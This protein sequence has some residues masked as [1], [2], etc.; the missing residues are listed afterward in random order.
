MIL[1]VA[2][3]TLLAIA[4]I[5]DLRTGRPRLRIDPSVDALL[6]TDDPERL[7][8][9]RI[10]RSFDGGASLILALRSEG[11]VYETRML[12]AVAGLTERIAQLDGVRA[13]RSLANA[14]RLRPVDGDLELAPL[15]ERPPRDPA[16]LAALRK[17]VESNPL[18]A[19]SLVSED[20]TVTTLVVELRE[21][22][23]RAFTESELDLRIRA[24]AEE[25]V[26]EGRAWL[27]GGPHFKAETSR[28]LLADLARIVPLAF[29]LV[30]AIALLA[31]RTLRGVLIPASSVLIA[32]VWTLGFTAATAGSL[33][34]V[35][36]VVP[37]LVLV[38]GFAYAVHVLAAHRD[39]AARAGPDAAPAAVTR[40][41]LGHVALP[42]LLAGLTT[43]AGL[44]ALA[45][46]PLRA[47]RQF[48]L[49]ATAGVLATM[50]VGLTW[51]PAWLA[52]LRPAAPQPKRPHGP[53]RVDRLLGR[54]A[55][56]DV[57]HRRVILAAG[58]LVALVGLYGTTRIEVRTNLVSSFP[59]DSDVRRD[60][61]A[62][63]AHLKGAGQLQVVVEAPAR[64]AFKEPE[65][66]RAIADLQRRL[67]E[68][69]Q[70]GSV[71]SLVDHVRLLNRG[72]HDGAPEHDRVPD[73]RRLVSQLLFFGAHEE[74]ARH[75]DTAYRTTV[76]ELRTTA[77][78]SD[79]LA[80]LVR[81]IER[82]G[83]GLPAGLEARVTG[84]N[85]LVVRALDDIARGQALS[86]AIAFG[87]IFAILALLFT[88]L[89]SGLMALLPNALPVIVYFGALGLAGVGLGATTGLV[90]CLVL[91]VAVDD[92]IH[93][94]ARFNAEARERADEAAGVRAALRSVGRPVTFTSV[95]LCLGFLVLTTAD[96]RNQV[97][98][99]AL[100]S[101]TLAVAWLVDVTFTPALAS[102][103]R[104]VTL[105]DVLALD[106]GRSPEQA[107]PLFHGLRRTQAKVAALLMD[108]VE[109]PAG[110]RLIRAGEEGSDLFVVIRG[111]LA[112]RTTRRDGSVVELGRHR[113]GD[114]VGEV[115]LMH[116]TRSADVVCETDAQLLR[117]EREDLERLRRRNPRTAARILQNLS[118]LLAQRLVAA[119][120][121][122][123][124]ST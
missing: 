94:L 34:L 89:R 27:A 64:D 53:D 13:V 69:P 14:L 99:G 31:F 35:T 19:G 118:E 29:L 75:V 36:V 1:A 8:Y 84:N 120:E 65:R 23:E 109:R 59:A 18:Y 85:A 68:L 54:L 95:A 90:A 123:E 21:M 58:A 25:A 72:F 74:I 71:T 79:D 87:A 110:H 32:L 124:R 121:R 7:F 2:A 96:L 60:V 101:F 49:L 119:T 116:G 9:D 55:D 83:V 100:A 78:D 26:G 93:L 20:A 11:D 77:L 105:W 37:P 91:G 67:E 10:Q 70:V 86:L 48:G 3:A 43:A 106:L 117:V 16:A 97:E 22:P 41:A 66:L 104:I 114:M 44:L 111:E 103:L 57:R 45:A 61:E 108:V 73:S 33:N 113:R 47:V 102:G 112:S 5:V 107:I 39:A 40:D 88:S 115:G 6:P 63:N 122:L 4:Q 50:V 17:S 24:L 12:E 80:D 28:V 76:L 52:L 38:V 15:F 56:L 82:L 51:A 62:V 92:T 30:C 81:R 98:F 46:S 42:T